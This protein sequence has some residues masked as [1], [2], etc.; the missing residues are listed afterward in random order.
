MR[1][2]D[3]HPIGAIVTGRIETGVSQLTPRN[4][5][6]QRHSSRVLVSFCSWIHVP[7]FWQ[8]DGG[9]HEA[10]SHLAPENPGLQIQRG[11]WTVCAHTPPLSQWNDM[12]P[13]ARS[14]AVPVKPRLQLHIGAAPGV[15][16]KHSPPFRHEGPLP[17][18]LHGTGAAHTPIAIV[19]NTATSAATTSGDTDMT[20]HTHTT[21]FQLH[22]LFERGVWTHIK[23]E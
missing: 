5:C 10:L 4:C 1:R 3:L 13:S 20:E 2:P 14:H 8:V 19:V 15:A 12:H 7:P 18:G 11:P 9:S 6:V 17:R 22:L 23:K 21:I 16:T